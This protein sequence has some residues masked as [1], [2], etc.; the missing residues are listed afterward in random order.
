[1]KRMHCWST[2]VLMIVFVLAAPPVRAQDALR[3][4]PGYVD[5]A[6]LD[7]WFDAEPK[8]EVNVKGAL[9]ELVAEASA[10]SN[11][12][13]HALLANLKAVQVR[14]FDA[15][16]E[17]LEMVRERGSSLARSLE[18]RGWETVVRV[19]EDHEFVNVFVK[20]DG[21]EI[22]GLMV[23]VADEMQ[24]EAIFVNVVGDLDPKEIGRLGRTLD[25]DPLK[26]LGD[27]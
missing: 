15:S 20:L 1:M 12:D 27:D 17:Q 7:G 24:D 8:L 26:D 5:F 11:P 18:R 23:M 19:R 2:A 21:R 10:E 14:G 16:R 22:S 13:A 9:L 6:E 25:I 3:A 4:E